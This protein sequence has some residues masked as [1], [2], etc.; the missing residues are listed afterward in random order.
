MDI[1]WRA[2]WTHESEYT[3]SSLSETV[4]AADSI[5]ADSHS[6]TVQTQLK[7]DGR[8]IMPRSIYHNGHGQWFGSESID[9]KY[10]DSGPMAR[11]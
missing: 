3:D 7:R 9:I 2:E 1:Y 4:S 11:G 6:V 5:T 8:Q 10:R